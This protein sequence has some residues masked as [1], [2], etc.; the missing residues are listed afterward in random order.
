MS[1]YTKLLIL[2][3]ATYPIV[4]PPS[5]WTDGHWWG[6]LFG[7]VLWSGPS[8]TVPSY[9][10]VVAMTTGSIIINARTTPLPS[11]MVHS[12]TS[13]RKRE[14]ELGWIEQVEEVTA[15]EALWLPKCAKQANTSK[16]E[17][18]SPGIVQPCL[19]R[20]VGFERASKASENNE[21]LCQPRN[22]LP[23][24]E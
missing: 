18:L 8:K 24:Q 3:V 22:K 20:W 17:A 2:S 5:V 15:I 23:T 21:G 10:L 9:H 13:D 11:W 1:A 6:I 4:K 19:E 7:K 16:H 12:N 14:A